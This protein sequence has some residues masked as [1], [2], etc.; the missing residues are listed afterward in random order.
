M[1]WYASFWDHSM[2]VIN[3]YKSIVLYLD[4]NVCFSPVS[5]KAGTFECIFFFFK[6]FAL[7][8]WRTY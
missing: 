6:K 7:E 5:S 4:P 1:Y 3:L 2:G 8:T